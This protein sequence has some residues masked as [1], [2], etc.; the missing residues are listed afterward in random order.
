MSSLLQPQLEGTVAEFK[1]D[2]SGMLAVR[3]VSAGNAAVLSPQNDQFF[4]F[5]QELQTYF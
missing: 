3:Q 2:R 1:V 5:T 4:M